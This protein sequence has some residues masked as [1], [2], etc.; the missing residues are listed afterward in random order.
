MARSSEPQLEIVAG[1]DCGPEPGQA[2]IDW[3]RLR[4]LEAF[5]LGDETATSFRALAGGGSDRW[6]YR[7][8]VGSLGVMILCHYGGEREENRLY[9]EV[10]RFLRDLG[11]RVPEI[12][13]HDPGVQLI[14]MEDLGDRDLWSYR[15]SSWEVR[16]EFYRSALEQGHRLHRDGLVHPG[17]GALRLCVPFDERL[18]RWEQEYFLERCLGAVFDVAP[19][20]RGMLGALPVLGEMAAGLAARPRVLIH[21]DFQS[22]NLVVKSGRVHLI[23]FQG[24]REGLAEYDLAALLYDPYVSLSEAEREEL[25]RMYAGMSGARFEDVAAV[26]DLCAV[27]RLMQA[28]GAYG[29]LGLE[30]GRRAFLRHIPAALGS[31]KTVA[32]RVS[33]LEML[34]EVLATLEPVS[35]PVSAAGGA[36]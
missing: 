3:L 20:V 10:A 23:D 36:M 11:V 6:F 22:Q 32:A 1:R 12:L 16:R 29:F 13:A 9:V 33:G 15:G 21:R 18:Y 4:T 7:A 28:L 8:E 2:S 25:L 30:R 19:D 34:G 35:E 31:L 17:C 5:R 24:M 14:W 27:Q 26:F